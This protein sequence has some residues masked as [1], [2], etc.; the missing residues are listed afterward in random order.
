[1]RI[2]RTIVENIVKAE[3]TKKFYDLK[4]EMDKELSE[5]CLRLVGKMDH[6]KIPQ[7]LIDN[8]Y[9]RTSST[10][11]YSY[12]DPGYSTYKQ[13]QVS[14]EMSKS[15]PISVFKS[16]FNLEYKGEIKKLNEKKLKL[17]QDEKDFRSKLDRT[18]SS[19]STHTA[20]VA[21]IPELK[22]HFKD[23]ELSKTRAVIPIEQ[24]TNL[25]AQLAK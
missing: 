9:V 18:L 7:D 10:A 19:F 8:H 16:S 25:R 4:N 3:T 14:I 22:H 5:A 24:I 17:L 6:P 15:F 21:Q 1:M 2:T 20:L 23:A 11:S 13:K 12:D